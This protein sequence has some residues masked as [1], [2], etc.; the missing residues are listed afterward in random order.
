M[1]YG[2]AATGG[3]SAYVVSSQSPVQAC[4]EY[5]LKT[6]FGY[7]NAFGKVR[8]DYPNKTDW[9]TLLKT[10]LDGGR[11]IL[12]AG[13]EVAAVTVLI[14]TGMMQMI[15]SILT[16]VGQDNLTGFLMSML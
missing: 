10:E 14:V 5:A 15:F 1:T 13:L 8:S 12:Y 9:Q 6:Y 2:I 4:A 3:S 7:P 16:G 11:P